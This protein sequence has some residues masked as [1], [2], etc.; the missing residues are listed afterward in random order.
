MLPRTLRDYPT[1]NLD[2][3]K[4]YL[5]PLHTNMAML[6]RTLKGYPI[7]NPVEKNLDAFKIYLSPLHT[8]LL[9]RTVKGYPVKNLA[10]PK[11]YIIYNIHIYKYRYLMMTQHHSNVL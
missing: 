4:I 11:T 9:P 2:A 7:K 1:K 3:P 6:P 5:L 10:A 8:N